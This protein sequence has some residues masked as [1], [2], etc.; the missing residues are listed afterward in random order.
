[1]NEFTQMG[2]LISASIAINASSSPLSS[3]SMNASIVKNA[4]QRQQIASH[5]REFIREW[6]LINVNI[7]A[8]A[9]RFFSN[10]QTHERIHPGVKPYKCKYCDKRFISSWK[11]KR[12]ERIHTGEK[13]FKCKHCDKSFSRS[14][15]CKV[16]ERIHTGVKPHKCKY[17]GKCFA[18]VGNCEQH[19]RIHTGLNLLK[20]YK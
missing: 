11:C 7:V 3:G 9:L 15:V 13:P 20:P 18:Q 1:M 12:H 5:T 2:N 17:C 6:N 19:E 8:R 4:L 14:H 16:H 10:C